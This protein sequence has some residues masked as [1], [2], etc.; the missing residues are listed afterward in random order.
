MSQFI[1]TNNTSKDVDTNL[2]WDTDP[3]CECGYRERL[4]RYC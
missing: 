3:K 2:G 1:K 4:R